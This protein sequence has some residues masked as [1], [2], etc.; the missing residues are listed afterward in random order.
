MNVSDQLIVSI[1]DSVASGEGNPDT[2]G[3]FSAAEW[4]GRRCHRSMLSD[5]Q[6][7]LAAERADAG[8]SISF[9]P[10][11]CSGR[12]SRRV[13]RRV[14]YP[15]RRRGGALQ[16]DLVN[17]IQEG[18]EIDA[19]IV[20]VGANDVGFSDIVIFCAKVVDCPDRRFDPDK[21]WKGEARPRRP[22]RC[23]RS[24]PVRSPTWSA[25][26]R[27][28][29]SGSRTPS[30]RIGSSSSSTSIHETAWMRTGTAVLPGDDPA[31]GEIAGRV[32]VAR[33]RAAQRAGGRG[34]AM[35]GRWPRTRRVLPGPRHLRREGPALD[36]QAG[37][38]GRA[39]GGPGARRAPC[40]LA[41]RGRSIRTSW[42]I[43]RRRS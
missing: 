10:L 30:Q 21:P 35:A 27:P 3:L 1:G 8:S 28:S 25:A 12:P 32:A 14:P 42:A 29:T 18:R 15:A 16:L 38:V 26:M 36:P 13:A 9:V 6:A 40:S 4:I 41:S 33:P 43:W 17:Q 2:G 39:A 22:G 31:V 5:T 37:R 11:G 7:A 24:L 20:S 34:A 23:A 19:L